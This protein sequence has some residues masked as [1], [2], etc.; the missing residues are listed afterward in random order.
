[1]GWPRFARNNCPSYLEETNFRSLKDDDL[2]S[3]LNIVSGT[4]MEALNQRKY[5]K[6]PHLFTPSSSATHNHVR[7]TYVCAPKCV[8]SH[9][10]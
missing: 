8:V 6:V 7:Y 1:M 3:R 9:P 10:M 5:T 2:I 4:F